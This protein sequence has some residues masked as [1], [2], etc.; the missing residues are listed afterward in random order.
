MA[1]APHGVERARPRA[2]GRFVEVEAPTELDLDGVKALG[3]ATVV[4]GRESAG[5]RLVVANGPPLGPCVLL[6]RVDEAGSGGRSAP[7]PRH[8]VRACGARS[9][10]GAPPDARHRVCGEKHGV[11]EPLAF[12]REGSG[13]RGMV[14]AVI[15]RE[16]LVEL[17]K[18]ERAREGAIA[19]TRGPP[20][21]A[22][23][24]TGTG[25]RSVDDVGIE[26]AEPAVQ[27]DDVARKATH[28]QRRARC[29]RVGVE[30]V[31]VKVR[32]APERAHRRHERREAAWGHEEAGVGD[33]DDDRDLL[34]SRLDELERL[35]GARRYHRPRVIVIVAA[36]RKKQLL[37]DRDDRS[38]DCCGFS[39]GMRRISRLGYAGIALAIAAWCS[40]AGAVDYAAP[41]PEAHATTDLPANAGGATSGKLV[42]PTGPGPYPLV[43]A[44][45]GWSASPDNQVGWAEHFAGYGF[46]VVVPGFPNP[47]S[48]VATTD[49]GIIKALVA[50]YANPATM[51]PAKGKVDGTRVGLE[52]HSAGGLATTVAAVD[53]K[54]QGV[55]LF[56][57]VDDSANAG[58][59]ALAKLCSPLLAIFA[60]PSSCNN[61]AGWSAFKTTSTGPRVLF[62]VVGSTHCDGES[63]A[64]ALCGSFCGGAADVTRQAEYSAHATAFLLWRLKGD[65]AAEA[66]LKQ[67]ALAADAKLANVSVQD[68]PSCAVTNAPPD[69][70]IDD[71]GKPIDHGDAATGGQDGSTRGNG[72][73]GGGAATNTDSP[74]G[75]SGGCA[76]GVSATST[77]PGTPIVVGGLFAIALRLRRKRHARG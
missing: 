75:T 18:R 55:V 12:L 53:L 67:A 21:Q 31:D 6:D 49:A 7:R 22:V 41:G 54:P 69:G 70:G 63:N 44:S 36:L 61:S 66:T 19:V 3:G 1:P 64:R 25:P 11:A 37:R 13:E 43:V 47:L 77:V 71:A 35:H 27:V 8:D 16:A 2:E 33:L 9:A 51:S 24:V 29:R 15:E 38:V 72:V 32:V 46:V 26:I 48:P 34:C 57:P 4:L 50:L 10:C 62:D 56:D 20:N 45:H 17:G 42:V 59:A 30:L 39:A 14:R 23:V 52:G 5:V 76:C 60:A 73:D 58:K 28:N 65:A 68:A 40:P 74:N